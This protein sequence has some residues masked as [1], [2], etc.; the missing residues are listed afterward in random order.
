M[1]SVEVSR[2]GSGCGGSLALGSRFGCKQR[3]IVLGKGLFIWRLKAAAVTLKRH[4]Y[5]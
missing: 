2:Q 5:P 3:S 4:P 1:D